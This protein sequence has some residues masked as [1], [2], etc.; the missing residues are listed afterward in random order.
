[1]QKGKVVFAAAVVCAAISAGVGFYKF[2]QPRENLAGVA[3][4]YRLSAA[5]LFTAYSLN[6]PR[7]DSFYLGQVLEISGTVNEVVKTDSSENISLATGDPAGN[8]NCGLFTRKKGQPPPPPPKGARITVKGK[9]TGF[10]ADVNLV[11]AII[12]SN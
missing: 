4:A 2:N 7:A 6:G 5:E 9:C 10:L 12:I 8:I 3:V 11:D 1:M